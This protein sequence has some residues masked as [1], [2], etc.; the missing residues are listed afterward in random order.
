[1]KKLEV[2]PLQIKFFENWQQNF[3]CLLYITVIL[4]IY[5]KRV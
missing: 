5:Y 1:M 4:N 2:N 3:L